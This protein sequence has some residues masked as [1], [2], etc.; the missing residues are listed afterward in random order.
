VFVSQL[1]GLAA[2]E[3]F[4]DTLSTGDLNRDGFDDLAIGAPHAEAEGIEEAGIITV[5]FGQPE[6]WPENYFPG[7]GPPPGSLLMAFVRGINAEDELSYS[8]EIRDYDDDGYDDIFT[9]ALGGDGKSEIIFDCGETYVLSGFHLSGRKVGITAIDPSSGPTGSPV[10]VQIRGSGFTRSADTRVFVDGEEAGGITVLSESLLAAAFPASSIPGTV[11]VIEL[12][13]RHG[14]AILANGFTYSGEAFF[15]RGDADSDGEVAIADAVYSLKYMFVGGPGGCLD[16][17]DTDDSG[18]L[19]INDPVMLL[20]HL[21]AGG[22]PPRPPFPDKGPDPS[23]D[24]LG[25]RLR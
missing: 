25:C 3:I 20:L 13:N 6:R 10:P 21:F 9:N 2:Q 7:L 16:A 19:D 22:R 11:A 15:N 5:M 17:M 4:G 23:P 24:S 8:M 12:R 1:H 14:S 18:E